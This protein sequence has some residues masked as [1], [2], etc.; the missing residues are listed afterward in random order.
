MKKYVFWP[1]LSLGIVLILIQSL[2]FTSTVSTAASAAKQPTQKLARLTPQITASAASQSNPLINLANG[3]ELLTSYLGSSEAQFTVAQNLARPTAL[4]SA[5]F[6]EDG[7]A[8]LI[9]GYAGPSGGILTVHRGNV[10]A[11]YPNSPEAKQR[12]AE[13]SFTEAPFLAPALVLELPEVPDFV[14]TGDFDADGHWDLAM[15]AKAGNS[16]YLLVGDGHG[17]FLSPETIV[18]PGG[19]SVLAAG[20]IN[21]ADGLTDIAVAI[22]SEQG[23]QVLVFEG[24]E[25]AL[26]SQPESFSL[27]GPA[28]G[29]VAG[30]LNSDYWF[31]LA[32]TAGPELLIVEG[33]DRKLSL[34]AALQSQV[35]EAVIN[36]Q[37]LTFRVRAM[38]VGDFN[39][40]RGEDLALLAEDGTL[41]LLTRGDIQGVEQGAGKISEW[42]SQR[43]SAVVGPG[44]SQLIT[45][46]VSGTGRDDLVIAD[47]ASNQLHIVTNEIGQQG[48]SAETLT[49][50]GGAEAILPMRLNGDAISDLVVL[51]SN[52]VAPSIVE[53]PHGPQATFTV[54]NTNDTGL[55][56]LRDA[57]ARANQSGGADVIT[58]NIGQGGA[59]TITPVTL[60]PTIT[61]PLT[62][63][64]TTQ[65]GFAGTPIIELNGSGLPSGTNALFITG[66]S[67]TVRGLVINR[68]AGS[69]DAI[70]FQTN[71]GNIVEGNFLGTDLSGNIALGNGN[72][73]FINGPPNNRIGGTTT[74]ARNVLSGNLRA[75]IAMGELSSTGN[76]VQGNFI[77]T[78]AAGTA[79]LGNTTNG[80]F[81]SLATSTIGGTVAGARNIISGN[82]NP[83]IVFN[84]S[85]GNLVQGNLIG[86]DV[87][88]TID[89]G[90]AQT[91]LQLISSGNNIIGGTTPAA[92][93]IVS[94]NNGAGFQ[95]RQIGADGN[96]VQ[97]NFIGTQIDGT[98]PLG[99]NLFGVTLESS[100]NNNSIGGAANRTGNTIA[101]NNDDGVAVFGGTGNAVLS[102][103]IFS[104]A[105]LGINLN[106]GG[107]PANGVTPNDS[108]DGDSGPNNVQN[109][110]VLTSVISGA[111]TVVQ[112]T[113]NSAANS[114]FTIQFF[115]NPACDASGNGEGRT[116]LGSTSM[117]TDAGGNGSFSAGVP[118]SLTA[119]QVVTATATD[120]SNNTS[121]F[122]VC[123]PVTLS[124]FSITGR[125]ADGAGQALR[126]VTVIVSGD[127]SSSTTTDANGNYSFASLATRGNYTVT[128]SSNTHSFSPPSR[129]FNNLT[130]N[131]IANFVATQT[132]VSISGK[133][134]GIGNVGIVNVTITLL[135]NGVASGTLLTD[136]LGN[137]SFSGLSAGDNYT[138]TPTGSFT[139][140]SLSFSNLAVD[141]I[142]NF[143]ATP[144]NP[145][146][147]LTIS[148]RLADSNNNPLPGVTLTL[149][150][151]ITRV[152]QAD[153]SG[154]YIFS[155]LVPG[156]NYVVTIQSPHYVFVPSRA[157]FL[158]LSSNQVANFTAAPVVV[159]S[160]LPP[161]NDDFNS[162]TRDANKWN[163]G[164]LTL[165]PTAFDPLV[166]VAQIN[167]QLRITP[168]T[169]VTGLHYN[170]YVSAN[171]FDLRGGAVSVELV[172]A[173]T[174]GADSIFAI[175]SDSDNFYRFLVHTAGPDTSL[176]P[177]T[178]G[179]NG[180][181][182]PA[183]TTVPQLVFQVN[184][185]GVL[186][187]LSIPYDPVQHR[188]M[189]FRHDAPANAILFETSPDNFAFTERHRVVLSRSVSALTA[190]LSA[191]TSNPT[192]PGATVFDNFGLV[193][194]TFQFSSANYTVEEGGGSIL[195][196]VTRAGS[197]ATAATVDYATSDGTARQNSDYILA[198]GRLIFAPGEGS[199]TF[200]V[201]IVDNAHSEGNQNL[202]LSLQD[203]TASG[204]NAPGSAVLN[205]IDND[206][207]AASS[208]PLED[209][210]FFV[211]Q[212]YY[213]FLNR[214]PDAGGLAFWVNQITSCGTDTQCIEIR[215]I[216]VSAAYFLSIEFQET[217]F[218]VHRFYNLALNRPNGLPRYLEFF[219]DTQ[220]IGNGVVV[221]APGWEALLEANRV[222]YANEFAARADF[223]ALYPLTLGAAEYVDALYVHAGITPSADE[224]QS[225]IAEFNNPAGAR[226]R[227]L[228]RVAENQ[229]LRARE[230]NRA[231]VLA[232]YFGYLRRNPDDA[233]DNN[234]DGYNFWLGKLNQFNGN[235]VNAEMVKAFITSG[236]Y[237][238]RFGP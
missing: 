186:T 160:T 152:A 153:A 210:T 104:N 167:G 1:S 54:T 42:I 29:M 118:A 177:N 3:R 227:V 57:I 182:T 72:G 43:L 47:S 89:L 21:R 121:E 214:V 166:N 41:H 120:Q 65:P 76:L 212:H 37:S 154:N 165:P 58:F 133:V 213:D 95:I 113:L 85:S 135:K 74:A 181:E 179:L 139:P 208:N 99:N 16:L 145:G 180:I 9:A 156:G 203:P 161:P 237:R 126:A 170:G 190:E 39:G 194:S 176:A 157:D 147:P 228:R 128:P 5:D 79:D 171:S 130:V 63:D 234:L 70:E 159:P 51:R 49:V 56:S 36:Q 207:T 136:N 112:G 105:Q 191:G 205:I 50:A 220:A 226:G 198:A 111:N 23:A 221:G 172:Q 236:E 101:F 52:Q 46:R 32:V 109:F 68:F 206:T 22:V 97:G 25:G 235:F 162:P 114:T 12:K 197:T 238:Q 19:V 62:I 232:Q 150:G 14:A 124:S 184:V 149:S 77:G 138:V 202:N 64:G 20:E 143:T 100:A 40:K 134:T 148:G 169:Q 185:G 174:G 211:T 137:Y 73:V 209:P 61:G 71:G 215:R 132:R 8:D 223:T 93:N 115:S 188:Y 44:A 2:L 48:A 107:D 15:A 102:N 164:T 219:K 103:S 158:T 127:A 69:G 142:A 106:F 195:I 53:S 4:A 229:T 225:A 59:Q 187:A 123:A 60:L 173:G 67:T 11:I 193:T 18:L 117:T 31:D 7:T 34:T 91:G 94:G 116:F 129:T 168:L 163:L 86:T 13:G 45:A 151:P 82:T 217:G 96:L 88:G 10:D 55:G 17:N 92:R 30:K 178:R 125:I 141:A 84:G 75:G 140:S 189:R 81:Q 24:P 144:A 98:S 224:R 26:K 196:T 33:R 27:P 218:L 38:S 199:K 146:S 66:G 233:P 200:Q 231:F 131:R 175:G 230:F 35:P 90:N 122:S 216:N 108:G 6:D 192:N 204:L 155:N 119:N 80:V 87:T 83:G 78:N 110:P 222:S 183:D 201:L 28:T